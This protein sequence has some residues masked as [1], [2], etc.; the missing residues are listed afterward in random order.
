MRA[1][2][3]LVGKSLFAAA[4]AAF[5]GVETN[6]SSCLSPPFTATACCCCLCCC[7]CFC[8][9]RCC[10]RLLP[11]A[12]SL[13]LSSCP[14]LL[15]AAAVAAGGGGGG[16]DTRIGGVLACCEQ[17]SED[18]FSLDFSWPLS[19]LQAFVAAMSIFDG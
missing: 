13:P 3:L 18:H 16:G 15:A 14:L 5:I 9:N 19:P 8:C 6:A 7:S 17:I 1:A 12:C 2:S 10:L 4:V 11:A